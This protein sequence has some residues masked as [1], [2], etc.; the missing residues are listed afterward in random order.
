MVSASITND[1]RKA[2]DAVEAGR[3]AV[4]PT[5]GAPPHDKGAAANGHHNLS[6]GMCANLS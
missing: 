4:D 6:K 5:L 2:V 3:A 1:T